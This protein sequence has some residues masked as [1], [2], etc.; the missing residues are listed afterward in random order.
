MPVTLSKNSKD[1]SFIKDGNEK[2]IFI[3][4][5]YQV[6]FLLNKFNFAHYK[7]DGKNMGEFIIS[8]D[9]LF[10]KIEYLDNLLCE[11]DFKKVDEDLKNN[12]KVFLKNLS[13]LYFNYQKIK[14]DSEFILTNERKDFFAHLK[15]LL[16]KN[17]FIPIC[18]PKSIGK[19]TT[20][21]YYLKMNARR[22]YFYINLNYC[23]KLLLSDKKEELYL[24]VCKELFNCM[25]F[26][27]V[28]KFYNYIYKKNYINIM[29][30]V[31]DILYY[32]NL[33]FPFNKC[34]ILIDQYKE[35][36]DKN[37][38]MIKKIE[39]K[40]KTSDKFYIIV[41]SSINEYDFRYSLNKKLENS[42]QFFLNYLFI[43]K[44]YSVD[45]EIAKK[46][47]NENEIQLL[48]NCG[49]LFIY[50]YNIKTNKILKQ[51]PLEKTKNEIKDHIINEINECL[52]IQD[53]SKKISI[54]VNLPPILHLKDS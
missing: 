17:K 19:T 14:E 29:E 34:Y 36:I 16:Q 40:T 12:T 41:C 10:S 38:E 54:A 15:T 44:L 48:D 5:A 37:Y 24:C 2:K 9:L 22:K 13:L 20:L 11:E 49:N 46:V 4:N 1:I 47:L 30:L 8:D 42:N 27:E 3:T 23:K 50:Y 18:G 43:N 32:M 51:N 21:L 53:N 45:K 39:I 33:N 7:V 31:D 35:K 6:L 52:D 25:T 26:K 28:I